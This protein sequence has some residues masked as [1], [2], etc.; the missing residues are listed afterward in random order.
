MSVQVSSQ[1]RRFL[2]TFAMAVSLVGISPAHADTHTV[3]MTSEESC[4]YNCAIV[5]MQVRGDRVRY[6]MSVAQANGISSIGWMRRHGHTISGL[7]SGFEC[8]KPTRQRLKVAG[9]GRRTHFVDM[10]VRTR[11]AARKFARRHCG[12]E[13]GLPEWPWK[14]MDQWRADYAKFCE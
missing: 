10:Q 6:K 12:L 14:T 13:C 1:Y 7:T 2:A 11:E 9:K 5:V 4:Q 8:D 3:Y